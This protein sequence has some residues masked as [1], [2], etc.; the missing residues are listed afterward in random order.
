MTTKT[1]VT[2]PE[3]T[4]VTETTDTAKAA[5][6]TMPSTDQRSRRTINYSIKLSTLAVGAVMVA[7]IAGLITLGWQLH[8]ARSDLSQIRATTS[9]RERA[10]Q[11]ATDYATGAAQM[12]FR[13]LQGWR[14]RLIQGT[15][16]ELSDRLTKAASS[17]E[18]IIAPL[19]W[20]STAT[21]ITAVAQAG[22]DG[23]FSVD[24]FVSVMTKNSQAPDGISSTATYKLTIDS[25]NDWKITEISG[26][27]AA[28]LEP[29]TGPR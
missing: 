15:S 7:M 4:A 26:I 22:P 23:T 9:D 13:D 8:D 1:E 21:P 2:E 12:D 18:Q 17:M 25:R 5:E 27:D 20:T 3:S 24:C 29:G 19:Q 16:P 11:I 10:E 28:A 6:D 14:A